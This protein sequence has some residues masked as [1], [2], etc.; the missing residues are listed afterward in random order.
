MVE[1]D[2]QQE[3]VQSPIPEDKIK[4][5][6][7]TGINGRKI[8]LLIPHTQEDLEVIKDMEENGLIDTRSSFGDSRKQTRTSD[9][10]TS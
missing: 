6:T 9:N 7:V 10:K 8:N 2:K 5:I 3:D 4:T 1:Q